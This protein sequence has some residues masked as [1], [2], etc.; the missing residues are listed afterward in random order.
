VTTAVEKRMSGIFTSPID[1]ERDI[2]VD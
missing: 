1:S 2:G